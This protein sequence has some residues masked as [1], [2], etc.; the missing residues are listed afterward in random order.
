MALTIRNGQFVDES[1]NVVKPEFGN[2]EM[3][4]AL[5]KATEPTENNDEYVDNL[6]PLARELAI[7]AEIA[8]C[9]FRIGEI[10]KLDDRRKENTINYLIDLATGYS[11]YK[12]HE[13]EIIELLECI[14]KNQKRLGESNKDTLKVLRQFKKEM[15]KHPIEK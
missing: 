5:K 15:K 14:A 4:D 8:F 11:E 12:A 9:V 1:G 6:P 7:G 2:R 3:I 13:E 10:I